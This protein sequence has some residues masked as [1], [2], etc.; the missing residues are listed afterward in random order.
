LTIWLPTITVALMTDLEA[1]YREVGRRLRQARETQGLSQEKLAGQLGLSRASIVNIEAGR[2]RAPLHLL[3]QI[4]E[5]LG[6]D[7]SLLIPR[8]EELFPVEKEVSLDPGMVKQ[9]KEAANGN[10]DTIKAITRFVSKLKTTIEI[11]PPVRNT[12][13]KRKHRKQS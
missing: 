13:E 9:I 10:V 1:L 6:T 4:S 2:Q 12:N 8:R 5:A 7:L 11:D 3:W